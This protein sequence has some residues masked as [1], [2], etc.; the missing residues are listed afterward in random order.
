MPAVPSSST[1]PPSHFGYQIVGT[2]RNSTPT[3]IP[4]IHLDSSARINC[5]VGN[6]AGPLGDAPTS[7]FVDTTPPPRVM[8]CAMYEGDVYIVCPAADVW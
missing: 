4:H 1:K 3:N 8:V 6:D 5:D 7:T 2:K